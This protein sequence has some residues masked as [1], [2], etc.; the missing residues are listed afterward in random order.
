VSVIRRTVYGRR[1]LD[2]EER[3][4]KKRAKREV[5]RTAKTADRARATRKKVTRKR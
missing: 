3:R 2:P 4:E 5:K 1:L